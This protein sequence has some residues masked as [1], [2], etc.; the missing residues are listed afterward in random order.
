M[1]IFITGDGGSDNWRKQVVS[2]G[3]IANLTAQQ[4][5]DVETGTIVTTT[6]GKR[7][8]YRGTGS[9]TSESSYVELADITP[10]WSVIADK[11][12]TISGYGITDA[13]ASNDSR[14][15]D[16]R[17]PTGAAGGDLT[18]TYPNP[19][20][21]AG[22]VVTADLADGAVTDAKI[23][24]GGLAASSINWAAIA[25][26]APNTAYAKGALVSFQGVAYRRSAAGTSGATFSTANWQQVTPT[27]NV[28]ATATALSANQNDYA[29]P[30]GA[31]IVR[32]S[33]T[34]AVTI[35]GVAA[36]WDGQAVLVINT[37]SNAITLAHASTSSSAGN[38]F[39]V[40]WAGNYVMDANG[41]AAL[42]VYDSTSS[43]WRVV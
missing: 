15:T 4:Q 10:V 43:V 2:S 26:W 6:D 38:R 29:L 14:L 23:T 36:G 31:D 35:T 28:V 30:A 3:G 42:L 25:A 12:S 20:I 40:P 11:P 7:W 9:K 19:Q 34:T 16:S 18:G 33:A 5:S 32:V 37:G 27:V 24:S 39:A 1:S 41:G 21:A 17:A 22:A 13:V 8:V